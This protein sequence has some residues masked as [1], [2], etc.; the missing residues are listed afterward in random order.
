MSVAAFAYAQAR[1]QARHGRRPDEQLWRRL[2][3]IGELGHYLQVARRSG[4][5][6]WVVG[7]QPRQS[8]DEIEVSLRGQLRA[9]VG[10]VASWLPP[11]WRAATGWTKRLPD[12][13]SIQHL[14]SQ[15]A[16][17]A[18]MMADSALEPF[19]AGTLAERRRAMHDS[20]CACLVQHWNPS[21]PLCQTWLQ[22]WQKLWPQLPRLA[23]GLRQ[24]GALHATLAG[25]ELA[26]VTDL[27]G[28]QRADLQG[29][30]ERVFRRYPFQPAA[31]FA[32][33]A[34]VALDVQQLRGAIL[35]RLLFD[36]RQEVGS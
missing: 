8:S 30:Y 27:S 6:R 29:A 31:V 33:L 7:M 18:W 1:L 34:L 9:Y 11:P 28:Q 16:I 24:L 19:T 2:Q 21:V 26:G 20:D 36:E 23:A 4:L 22:C 35:R 25:I 13:A 10:E 15:E 17:P 14:L 12:L 3:G 5:Q 32:H